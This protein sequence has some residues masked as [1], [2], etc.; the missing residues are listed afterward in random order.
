MI[1]ESI[2]ASGWFAESR[3]SDIRPFLHRQPSL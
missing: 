2:G 1:D 3:E